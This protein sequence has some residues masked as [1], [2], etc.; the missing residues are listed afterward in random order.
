M[1]IYTEN[2]TR[3]TLAGYNTENPKK[4]P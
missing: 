3:N 4:H 1:I 2:N